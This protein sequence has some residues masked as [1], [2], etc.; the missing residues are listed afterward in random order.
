M[1]ELEKEAMF[2]FMEAGYEATLKT[3]WPDDHHL[4]LAP[5]HHKAW[6]YL[7]EIM[8]DTYYDPYIMIWGR[9]SAKSTTAERAT[10]L[11]GALRR[12]KYV[13]YVSAT[14]DSADTHI[15]SIGDMLTSTPM[16]KYFPS[17]ANRKVD[18]EGVKEGWRRNRLITQ[19]GFAIDALGLDT[20]VRGRKLGDQRP[21]LIVIDDIDEQL[22][23][24][25]MTIKKQDA[26]AQR[27]IPAG[28]PDVVV[29]GA[30]NLITPTGIFSQ[31]AFKKSPI[32][33]KA[34][35]NGPIPA[36]Y[37]LQIEDG[38]IIGGTPSWPERFP[39]EKCQ[40][41][42]DQIG[43][44]AFLIEY[45]HDVFQT[46]G[47]LY[48]REH[49]H[50]KPLP[51]QIQD[52]NIGVDPAMSDSARAD[53][54]GIYVGALGA[55]GDLYVA[56]SRSGRHHPSVTKQ[57][58]YDLWQKY[59]CEIWIEI[60]NGGQWLVDSLISM[61]IPTKQVVGVK[62]GG[63]SKRGRAQPIADKAST[64]IENNHLWLCQK[65]EKLENQ[66]VSW[67]PAENAKSPDHLDGMT[68][69]LSKWIQPRVQP[70]RGY[71]SASLYT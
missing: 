48:T 13:W 20:A 8:P 63:I 23:T 10:A 47:A 19:S 28:T 14:Q 54:S 22:D 18:K 66:M 16:Q 41:I 46:S 35:I 25:E 70:A 62:S 3:L 69:A 59:Q 53:E 1:D 11:L 9:G 32:L 29:I 71:S 57:I 56:E 44:S 50:Y 45:N 6:Q 15:L 61:G 37:D 5:F 34:I 17:M 7:F 43:T 52:Y 30:Q 64:N 51:E 39:I 55:D 27:L 38:Q 2:A 40:N 31:F 26:I 42:V 49:I 68:W 36:I 67:V 60:D 33:K 21:D 4:P 24:P 12:R 65:F 58:A